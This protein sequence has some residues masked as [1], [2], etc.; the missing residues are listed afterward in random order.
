[1]KFD[2]AILLIKARIIYDNFDAIFVPFQKIY[3]LYD[4]KIN[5]FFFSQKLHH[6]VHCLKL[7]AVQYLPVSKLIHTSGAYRSIVI[8]I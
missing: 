7:K 4:M 5:L 6:V 2:I 3:I 1:M 8:G